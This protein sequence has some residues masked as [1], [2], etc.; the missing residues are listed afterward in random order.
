MGNTSVEYLHTVIECA[1]LAFADREVY[2][3][4][5][6]VDDVPFD[7]LLSKDYAA[8]RRELIGPEAS[9]ELRPGDWAIG[10][11][12]WTTFDVLEDNRQAALQRIDDPRR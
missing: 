2:Y 4:D 5:P 12:E 1:K 8:R 10:I 9:L 3:G 11:P 6:V 7:V